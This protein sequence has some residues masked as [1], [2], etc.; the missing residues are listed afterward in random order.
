MSKK[1]YIGI[2]G[3]I[4]VGKTTLAKALEKD[5][6]KAFFEPVDTNPYL[7]LFYGDMVENSFKMQIFL[8]RERFR[9][10]QK[11]GL[12]ECNVVQDRTI[13]EDSVFARMLNKSGHMTDLDLK[14]YLDLFDTLSSLMPR[15]NLIV[16]L[17]VEPEEA[18]ANIKKRGRFCEKG[19]TI[20]YLTALRDE[21]ELFI[22]E[23]SR[24]VPVL[25][26]KYSNFPSVESIVKA[27]QSG[28]DASHNIIEA[29]LQ[30]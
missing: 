8:L 16:Y 19:I 3:L 30:N 14:T 25:R 5:G 21:Y 24:V 15:P 11:I 28:Y 1:L 10:Q 18:L 17:E 4:G 22:K 6:W 13:Y 23:I 12:E 2:S 26:I 7:E 20:Q 27:V 29:Q 9:Q